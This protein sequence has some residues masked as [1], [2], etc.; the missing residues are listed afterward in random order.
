MRLTK[1]FCEELNI[2]YGKLTAEIKSRKDIIS[3]YI[4][5]CQHND[6]MHGSFCSKIF[7]TV[8]PDEFPPVDS[9][10]RKFFKLDSEN[11]LLS[12][13]IIKQGYHDYLKSNY[14]KIG[15]IKGLKSI[16]TF[17]ILRLNELSYIR[18]IDMIIWWEQK[19]K[20]QGRTGIRL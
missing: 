3:F 14:N 8:F 10:I 2:N 7:H 11:L 20:T 12:I 15:R 1:N 19:N 18:L 9:L 17:N 4:D 6:K 16:S 5:R 13:L